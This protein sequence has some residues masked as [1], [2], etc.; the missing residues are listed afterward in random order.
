MSQYSTG[1][2]VKKKPRCEGGAKRKK[3]MTEKGVPSYSKFPA[4]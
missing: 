1:N 3:V 4:T 2:T